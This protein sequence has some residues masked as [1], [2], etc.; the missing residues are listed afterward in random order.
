MVVDHRGSGNETRVFKHGRNRPSFLKCLTVLQQTAIMYPMK[1]M[2]QV[3]LQTTPDQFLALKQTLETANDACNYISA[4]A[5]EHKT[6]NQFRLHKLTYRTVRKQFGLTAQV[7]VRCI[8]KVADAYKLDKK[9]KRTFKP[10]SAIA[11]DDRI[12]RWYLDKSEVSIWT[13]AG[14]LRLSFLCGEKQREML[15]HRRGESDLVLFRNNFY[16]SAVCEIEEPIPTEGKDVLGI[17]MGVVNIA[18]DSDGTVYS[19]KS[20]NHVRA[21]HR[22]LRAKLQKKS[23]KSA[24]R[25]LKK[26]SGKERRFAKHTNHCISK[27][28]VQYAK[29]TERDV[30]IEDL[31]GIRSRTTV[32]RTQRAQHDSWSFYQLRSFLEYK[33]KRAGVRLFAVGP[34]NTSRT[35]PQCGC[36]D[37]HN[38][39]NQSTFC[40]IACG[41]SGLA[42]YIAARII[43][44]RAGVSQPHVSASTSD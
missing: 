21:R 27:Q 22:H 41:Y 2:A 44:G 23:T 10:R 42:D 16:L 38:R 14:R 25:L 40:C 20:I 32:R 1:L 33:S 37:K 28:I 3:K 24:K 8:S 9:R 6:F 36:V 31:K 11:F 12:L 7:A 29:D 26:L 43:A 4:Q 18:V 30:A 17:D 15:K 39:P 13:V 19:A 34:R 5:W 35:C